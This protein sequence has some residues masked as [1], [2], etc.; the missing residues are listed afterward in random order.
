MADSLYFSLWFSD[1][2]TEEMLVRALSVM[3]QFP[4]SG[5]LPGITYF[6]LHPVSWN[7]PTIFEQRFRPG[8]SPEEAILI[9]SDLLHEDYAYAFEANWDLWTPD[10]AAGK[11][12]AW[13]L[14]PSPVSLIVRGEEF[15][16]GESKTQ[17]EVQL[18]FGLDTPFLHEELQLTSEVESRVRANVQMLV[19]FINRVE[20]SG[21]ASTRLLWSESD[22]NLAQKL[23]DRLQKVQ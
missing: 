18:D 16:E 6:A 17:G 11:D 7:E 15:A 19:D 12:E 5:T 14:R 9:A 21:I 20:K 1:F 2:S 3:R 23:V 4:F 22:E 8:A 10:V 13:T